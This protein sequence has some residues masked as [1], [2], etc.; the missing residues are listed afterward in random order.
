MAIRK[1]KTAAEKATQQIDDIKEQAKA[2]ITGWKSRN[3]TRQQWHDAHDILAELYPLSPAQWQD[4]EIKLCEQYE[5][6]KTWKGA[7][8]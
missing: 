3:V 1:Q 6:W 5:N 4:A 7:S 8:A 2:L